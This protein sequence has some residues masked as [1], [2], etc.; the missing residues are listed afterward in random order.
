M[1]FRDAQQ[2]EDRDR[3]R[4]MIASL[5]HHMEEQRRKSA[6]QLEAHNSSGNPKRLQLVPAV[7]GTLRRLEE[8]FE[9]R[10]AEIRA[11]EVYGARDSEVSSGVIWVR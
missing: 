11:K 1:A 2:R 7:M 3:I 8:K 9:I 4:L 5:E 6:T 10:M